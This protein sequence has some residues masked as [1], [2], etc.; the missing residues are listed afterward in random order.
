MKVSFR[1]H[2]HALPVKSAEKERVKMGST[3]ATGICAEGNGY[4]HQHRRQHADL[5]NSAQPRREADIGGNDQRLP[6]GCGSRML[7]SCAAGNGAAMPEV[8]QVALTT[9]NRAAFGPPSS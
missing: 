1:R 9:I 3:A 7:C 6:G 2:R 4:D 5:R 8:A